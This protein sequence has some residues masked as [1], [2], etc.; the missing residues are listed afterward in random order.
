[1]VQMVRVRLPSVA[2]TTTLA[3]AIERN[4][5]FQMTADQSSTISFE[6]DD[7]NVVVTMWGPDESE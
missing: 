7:D 3:L 6:P 1:M 2:L 4:A 5:E